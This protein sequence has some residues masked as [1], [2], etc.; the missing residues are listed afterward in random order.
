MHNLLWKTATLQFKAVNRPSADLHEY[1]TNSRFLSIKPAFPNER[2][3]TFIDYVSCNSSIEQKSSKRLC[4]S[5][6]PGSLMDLFLLLF[7]ALSDQ[8]KVS[9][10]S[11]KV[12]L[13]TGD[14]TLWQSLK[15]QSYCG[16]FARTSNKVRAKVDQ[17]E[18]KPRSQITCSSNCCRYLKLECFALSLCL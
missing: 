5:L 9:V 18:V 7:W 12:D 2:C 14:S 11:R 17:F 13:S 1:Q 6:T 15:C 3:M 4:A 10:K 16:H 8:Q